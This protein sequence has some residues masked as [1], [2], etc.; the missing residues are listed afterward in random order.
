MR[1][2]LKSFPLLVHICNTESGTERKKDM[3]SWA[4][5]FHEKLIYNNLNILNI[6]QIRSP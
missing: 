1:K 3:V 4:L 5:V 2:T 6:E